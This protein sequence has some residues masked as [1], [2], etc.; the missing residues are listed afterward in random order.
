MLL[1]KFWLLNCV[2]PILLRTLKDGESTNLSTPGVLSTPTPWGCPAL[3]QL[4]RCDPELLARSSRSYGSRCQF[5]VRFH[6]CEH[7]IQPRTLQK[8]IQSDK[9]HKGYE[10]QWKCS[11]ILTTPSYMGGLGNVFQKPSHLTVAR[12]SHT[13]T[14]IPFKIATMD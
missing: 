12:H 11:M 5:P 4:G 3:D 8:P 6:G 1:G 10:T 2:H 7:Q 13:H 14:H 9:G